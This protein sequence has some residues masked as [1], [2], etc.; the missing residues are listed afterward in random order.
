MIKSK[1]GHLITFMAP[2][3]FARQL[4]GYGLNESHLFYVFIC[5]RGLFLGTVTWNTS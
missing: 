5:G 2:P 3:P 1:V 4:L